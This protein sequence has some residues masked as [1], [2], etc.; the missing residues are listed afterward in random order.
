MFTK[1]YQKIVFRDTHAEL[2]NSQLPGIENDQLL[3]QSKISLISPGTERA[4]LTRLWDDAGFRENPGYSLAGEV[5]EVGKN[6]KEF[7]PGDRVY[8]LI[9][10]G[11]YAVVSSAPWVTLKIPDNVSY[12][13]ATFTALAS[14]AMHAF[15]RL[16]M[17]LGESVAIIGA[18]IIGQIVTQLARM[19][20]AK[21]IIVLDMAD[22][23][24]SLASKY[25]ADLTI[26]PG[27][28][29]VVKKLNAFTNGQGVP[30]ILEATGNTKVLPIA[31]KM[32]AVGGRICLAGVME[33]P[34][35]LA[36][37]Q[38]FLQR[39]LTLIAAHQPHCPVT[40]NIYY[41]WTQQENR[42]LVMEMLSEN[43]LKVNEMITHRFPAIKV[44]D[45][46]EKVKKGDM[47]ML[48]ALFEW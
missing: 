5:L 7:K 34:H 44:P 1:S 2:I 28:E 36:F 48:G 19:S 24:L 17:E 22:N 8:S 9:N 41:H 37:H 29:E 14:V 27:K 33:E 43:K 26:N 18:G 23:R 3:I 25:G 10:H 42:R 6:V 38:E 13:D 46:Y 32:A 11:N 21:K 39:E 30:A 16:K 12:E 40:E 47:D 20:G 45:A 4:A 31:F 35:P 15:R